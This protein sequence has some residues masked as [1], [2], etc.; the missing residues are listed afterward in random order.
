MSK[1]KGISL[2]PVST[3]ETPISHSGVDRIAGPSRDDFNGKHSWSRDGHYKAPL[4]L[5]PG[6][7]ESG[8]IAALGT[9]SE[10]CTPTSIT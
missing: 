2:A 8:Y 6:A 7:E 1:R 3:Q 5:I 9:L 10:G 4:P